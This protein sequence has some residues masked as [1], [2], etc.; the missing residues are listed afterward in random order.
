[1]ASKD[2]SGSFPGIKLPGVFVETME[3][4]FSTKGDAMPSEFLGMTHRTKYIHSVGAVGK[5][6]F[7][8]SKDHQYTGIFEGADHGIIRLSSA[9]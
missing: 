3:P 4:T 6:K 5:V 8:S 1:M 9:V 2:K 7:V